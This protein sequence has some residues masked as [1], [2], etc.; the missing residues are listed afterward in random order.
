MREHIPL[1][2]LGLPIKRIVRVSS[3]S[4]ASRV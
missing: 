2:T 1:R 3:P 4:R